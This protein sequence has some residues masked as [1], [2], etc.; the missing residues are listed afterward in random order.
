MMDSGRT[1]AAADLGLGSWELNWFCWGFIDVDTFF[2]VGFIG[3]ELVFITGFVGFLLM[4]FH[5]YI[6]NNW[7]I[8]VELVYRYLTYPFEQWLLNLG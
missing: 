2:F 8:D 3:V 1:A 5:I 7:F 6:Y 4:G